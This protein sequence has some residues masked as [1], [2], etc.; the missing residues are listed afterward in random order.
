MQAAQGRHDA[1]AA[2]HDRDEA[3]ESLD[4]KVRNQVRKAE[5]SGLAVECWR[6]EILPSF[7]GV[8]A[9]N[10]RDLGTPVYSRRLFEE[11]FAQFPDAT[12]VFVVQARTRR[13]WRRASRIGIVN[14]VEVP[15]ASSLAEYRA[16]CP[17]NLLYW[18]VIEWAIEQGLA[19]VGLRA[20][21]ARRGHVSLQDGNGAPCHSRCAGS[22]RSLRR[23]LALPD[24]SP[25]NPKFAG[26]IRM[27]KRLP[28]AVA[29]ALGPL[30][31]RSIP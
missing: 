29:S 9:Q 4:R 17:N 26:A 27:W 31:V 8:F 10:M 6:R 19:Y 23:A 15:W 2:R 28:L 21:D 25:K 16:M 11:V 12:R 30:I 24:Q 5:K 7:Y 22:M 20:V 18:R 1:A 13:S 3:W 14:G